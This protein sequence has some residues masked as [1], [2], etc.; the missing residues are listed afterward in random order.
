MKG[1]DTEALKDPKGSAATLVAGA[2]TAT[3]YGYT[4]GPASCTS[5]TCTTYTL[6]ADLEGSETNYSKSNLN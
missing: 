1:L 3:A 4:V 2:A 6:A 5:T